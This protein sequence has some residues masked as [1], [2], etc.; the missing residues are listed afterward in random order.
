MI[1]AALHPQ[2]RRGEPRVGADVRLA[3]AVGMMETAE[4][5]DVAAMPLQRL[6]RHAQ[7][8]VAPA[9]GDLPGEHL[10][11]IGDVD[12]NT[13]ARFGRGLRGGGAQRSHAIEQREGNGR[14]DAAK[15]MP[16]AQ[17]PV[18]G[19]DVAHTDAD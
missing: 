2:L 3:D 14:A 16:A 4:G 13:P 5:G 18:L 9:L 1:G 7:F 19:E 11:A 6:H 8:I 15:K 12:E 10:H 17:A